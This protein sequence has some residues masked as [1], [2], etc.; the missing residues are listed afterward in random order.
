MWLH[1]PS[2]VIGK[3]RNTTQGCEEL[4]SNEKRAES[5]L[6]PPVYAYF[7]ARIQRSALPYC[8]TSS[9]IAG[10]FSLTIWKIHAPMETR[11][12]HLTV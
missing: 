1:S 2:L 12:D 6:T 10:A 7:E 8:L 11:P 3:V 4:H 9:R 5:K